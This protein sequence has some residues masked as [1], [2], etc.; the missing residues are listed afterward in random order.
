MREQKH[1]KMFIVGIGCF[2]HFFLSYSI[3][4]N[5]T[6]EYE[7]RKYIGGPWPIGECEHRKNGVPGG[8]ILLYG[9]TD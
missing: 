1:I 6:L 4:P 5:E 2:H 3:N 8:F 9:C 7:I